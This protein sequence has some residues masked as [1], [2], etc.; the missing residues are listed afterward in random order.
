MVKFLLYIII[1]LICGFISG[2]LAGRVFTPEQFKNSILSFFQGVR[3]RFDRAM[4]GN[5]GNYSNTRLLETT[6]SDSFSANF[7]RLD[8]NIA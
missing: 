5:D 2:L 3:N 6:C 7:E 8:R 4:T 1:S